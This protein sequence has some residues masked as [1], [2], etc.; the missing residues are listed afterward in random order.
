[1]MK[2]DMLAKGLVASLRQSLSTGK[3]VSVPPGG[4]LIWEWFSDLSATRSWHM[5]GPNP[6][7]Y[8]EIAAY[9]RLMGW[10]IR[11]HHVAILQAMDNAFLTDFFAKRERASTGKKKPPLFSTKDMN[12]A[13]FDAVFG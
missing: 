7:S 5:N 13:L 3:A 8:A 9:G 10:S 6:I 11:P 12:P 4:S 1:M 2:H